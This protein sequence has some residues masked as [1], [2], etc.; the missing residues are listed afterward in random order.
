MDRSSWGFVFAAD[1]SQPNRRWPFRGDPDFAVPV[2]TAYF[3][4]GSGLAGAAGLKPAAAS[5][6]LRFFHALPAV[7]SHGDLDRRGREAM[8]WEFCRRQIAKIRHQ[9]ADVP[10]I[11]LCPVG[12]P[13]RAAAR[14]KSALR[15]IVN[16]DFFRI[17]PAE[18]KQLLVSKV[19]QALVHRCADGG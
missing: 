19:V 9:R 3:F 11:H 14:E 4:L 12:P 10:F 15:A 1:E 13:V 2:K 5:C 7:G 16:F 6:D 17:G 8:V 18:I